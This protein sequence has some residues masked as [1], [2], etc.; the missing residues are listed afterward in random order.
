MSDDGQGDKE[1]RRAQRGA[2]M[3]NLEP[4]VPSLEPFE[5]YLDRLES[6]NELNETSDSDKVNSLVV[7][8]GPEMYGILKNLVSPSKVK[9]KTFEQL[10]AIL[11][12]HYAPEGLEV[13]E[14]YKFNS[15]DQRVGEP[16]R[17]FVVALKKL[18]TTCNFG[19]FLDEALRD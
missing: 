11:R 16:I 2:I 4:Y 18:A 17:K 15:R 12:D 10:C 3:G 9:D 1:L 6:F 8:I 14:R 7:L 19:Q 13:A 5:N